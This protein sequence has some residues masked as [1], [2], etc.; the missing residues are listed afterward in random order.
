MNAWH[1]YHAAFKDL[2]TQGLL[3]RPIIPDECEHNAHMYYLLLPDSAQRDRFIAHIK[4]GGVLCFFHYVPLHLSAYI[5]NTGSRFTLP[6]TEEMWKRL[7]R[8][9]MW[10][11]V[12]TSYVV[13]C[14]LSFF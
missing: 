9:P 2:E 3:R 7:V 13:D 11:G 8:I 12:N 5:A 14:A 1:F 4:E 6:I 10:V